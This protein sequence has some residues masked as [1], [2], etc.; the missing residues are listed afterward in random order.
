MPFVE[1]FTVFTSDFGLEAVLAGAPVKVIFD[2]PASNDLGITRAEP[3]VQI[4]TASVPASVLNAALVVP[5]QGTFKVREHLPDGTG[6][7]L[8]VLTRVSA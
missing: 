2:A 6:W 3:Q 1:D 4:A 7:S 5:G 8:L